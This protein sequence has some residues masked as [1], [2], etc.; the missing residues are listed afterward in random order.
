MRQGVP[1]GGG[2]LSPLLFNLY[3]LKMPTLPDDIRLVTYADDSTVLCSGKEIQT[4]CN[5]L[6]PY[7]DNLNNWFNKINLSLSAPKSSATLFT[8]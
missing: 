3:M 2:V 7:L 6:N 1:Q 8:T 5:T 4:I